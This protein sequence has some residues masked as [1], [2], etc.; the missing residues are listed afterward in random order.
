MTTML[1]ELMDELFNEGREEATCAERGASHT[2][3][4]ADSI[5]EQIRE[6][7]SAKDAR[8]NVLETEL[9]NRFAADEMHYLRSQGDSRGD[10]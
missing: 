4:D 10:E 2:R 1:E 9:R 6:L 5:K 7:V 3:S 8:I